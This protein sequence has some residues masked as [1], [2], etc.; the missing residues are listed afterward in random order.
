MAY[1]ELDWSAYIV[2]GVCWLV[3]SCTFGFV[4]AQ[5]ANGIKRRK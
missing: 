4:I 5:I 2:V 3:I 1:G